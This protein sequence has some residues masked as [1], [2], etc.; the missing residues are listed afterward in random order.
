MKWIL[1]VLIIAFIVWR[2]KSPKDVRSIQAEAVKPLLNDKKKQLIDVRTVAEYK[3]RHI[4][5]FKNIPLNTL[6]NALS[7][8]DKEKETIVIC[9]S[10]MRSMQAARQL[11]KAGFTNIV[12]VTGGM[13]A[14][15]D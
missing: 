3:A 5:Q 13:N 9:Q 1:I 7:N 10:G 15:R 2:M 11:S 14:W 6:P 8:L 12:N 4:P